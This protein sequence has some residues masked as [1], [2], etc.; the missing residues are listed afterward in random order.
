[1]GIRSRTV[2][3]TPP[4]GDSSHSMS[5][6]I[7]WLDACSPPNVPPEMQR[8]NSSTT[9]S[10]SHAT[11]VEIDQSHDAG[12]SSQ[13]ERAQR[14]QIQ[15]PIATGPARRHQVRSS[16]NGRRMGRKHG[17]FVGID[18]DVR[19]AV[20]D[21]CGQLAGQPPRDN[22]SAS[23]VRSRHAAAGTAMT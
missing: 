12:S 23:N 5:A 6:P 22:H 13:H 21:Q 14:H 8:A 15:L 17:L 7:A 9:N 3:L 18:G 19:I 1:M 16:P 20:P 2:P 10:T 11:E 4:N